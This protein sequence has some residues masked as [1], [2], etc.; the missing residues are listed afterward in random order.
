MNLRIYSILQ[1]VIPFVSAKNVSH[2]GNKKV[3]LA[4]VLFLFYYKNMTS[5]Q[6]Y[7]SVILIT[8]LLSISLLPNAQTNTRIKDIFNKYK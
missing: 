7:N 2:T 6:N 8:S 5:I 1:L 4:E 3:I